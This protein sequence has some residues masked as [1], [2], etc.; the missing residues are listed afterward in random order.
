LGPYPFSLI[1]GVIL[2]VGFVTVVPFAGYY[3]LVGLCFLSRDVTASVAAFAAFGL[4]RGLSVL[5]AGWYTAA[6]CGNFVTIN[7]QVD[8]RLKQLKVWMP[9]LRGSALLMAAGT[10]MKYLWVA[11]G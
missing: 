5:V 2:G 11:R 3:V 8:R 4:V 10:G 7:A 6:A 1:F 9:F